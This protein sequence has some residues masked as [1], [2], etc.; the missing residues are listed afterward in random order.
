M[1]LLCFT[2]SSRKVPARSRRLVA[3]VGRQPSGARSQKKGK[4]MRASRE[5]RLLAGAMLTIGATVPWLLGCS[6]GSEVSGAPGA[7]LAPPTTGPVETGRTIGSPPSAPATTGVVAT[8]TPRWTPEQQEVI[9]AYQRAIDAEVRVTLSGDSALESLRG[10]HE[11]PLLS[12]IRNAVYA[13]RNSGHAVHLPPSTRTHVDVMA[14]ER[15]D[16]GS[17]RLTDC[18][19][20]DAIVTQVADGRVVNDRVTTASRVVV[21]HRRE[22]RWLAGS[23]EVVAKW[24]GIQTCEGV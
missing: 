23:R 19:V 20:D 9:D 18:S 8:T 12:T 5:R 17:M 22:G 6:K 14:V 10:T 2:R 15:Q 16:D 21:L 3:R 24:E 4:G 1:F 13:E 7:T 11:D